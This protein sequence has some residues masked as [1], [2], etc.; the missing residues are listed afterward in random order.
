MPFLVLNLKLILNVTQQN[1]RRVG[2][3]SNTDKLP[4]DERYSLLARLVKNE[5]QV[6]FYDSCKIYNILHITTSI[7]D[8]AE[9]T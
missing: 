7:N 2:M 3:C 4:R 1:K 8:K 9:K 6:L 5:L